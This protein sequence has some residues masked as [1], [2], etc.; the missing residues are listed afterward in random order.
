M[1]HSRR[2]M[3]LIEVIVVIAIVLGLTVVMVPSA[4]SL[5][6]LNQRNAARKLAMHFERF[7]DEAVMRNR[8]FRFTTTWTRT[9]T[10]SSRERRARSSAR[11]PR[12]ASSTRPRWRASSS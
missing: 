7:H 8:S 1:R 2:G 10:S 12:S 4:R 5:F 3:S 11:V 9:A 6:E